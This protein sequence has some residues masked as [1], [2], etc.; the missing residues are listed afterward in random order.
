MLRER[1][2]NMVLR[3][4]WIERDASPDEFPNVEHALAEP[5]GL[6]AAGGDLSPPRLLAAYRRGIFPWYSEGQPIL[7]WCPDPRAVLCPDEMKVSRSLRK[8]IR[9]GHFRITT[10]MAFPKVVERCAA[11]RRDET[12]TWI[13]EEMKNAYIRLHRL[14]YAHSVECWHEDGLVGGLYGIALGRVFFGE[15]MFSQMN[16]VSKV[17]LTHLRELDFELIDCQVPSGHLAR[18]GAKNM[19]RRAFL[20]LLDRWCEVPLAQG[21]SWLAGG[22]A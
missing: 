18:L 20:R 15:S 17:A 22:S 12:G 5:N 16:D 9:R 13:T 6:L 14:G 8:T 19:D 10:D 4:Y 3:P 11:P 7:W 2:G 21:F 1:T